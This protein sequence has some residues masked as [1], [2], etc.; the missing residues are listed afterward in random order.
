MRSVYTRDE[1][2]EV[3]R[4]LIFRKLKSSGPERRKKQNKKMSFKT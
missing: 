2:F 1:Q 3:T 4:G